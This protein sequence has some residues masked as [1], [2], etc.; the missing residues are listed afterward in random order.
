[1]NV[2]N[3]GLELKELKMAVDGGAALLIGVI[4]LLDGGE[5]RTAPADSLQARVDERP[6]ETERLEE[7]GRQ[8][9]LPEQVLARGGERG[10]LV[11]QII[12]IIED[13]VLG[14]AGGGAIVAEEERD[15]SRGGAQDGDRHGGHAEI[16]GERET[17]EEERH[18]LGRAGEVE[19]HRE[20]ERGEQVGAGADRVHD[21]LGDGV[22]DRSDRLGAHEQ[23]Q[24]DRQE[25]EEARQAENQPEGPGHA[26][27]G[28]ALG[29]IEQHLGGDQVVAG[30][31]EVLQQTEHDADGDGER[32]GG[33]GGQ[34]AGDGEAGAQDAR[35]RDVDGNRDADAH[36]AHGG[37]LERSADDDALGQVAQHQADQGAHHDGAGRLVDA[38]DVLAPAEHGDQTEQHFLKNGHDPSFPANSN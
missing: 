26:L 28:V 37:E 27:R 33:L 16:R 10:G 15:R 17:D 2:E 29:M 30:G 7:D 24:E 4:E 14:G 31:G 35:D 3:S 34:A 19:Q 13:V 22:G 9:L 36:H 5:H 32:D 11:I 38:V 25:H 18:G 20:A 1:M 8:F 23:A 6:L 12:E 21:V